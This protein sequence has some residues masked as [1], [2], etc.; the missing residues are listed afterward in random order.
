MIDKPPDK[1]VEISVQHLS[2]VY[3]TKNKGDVLALNDINI[4]FFEGEITGVLGH[5][6]AGKSTLLSI[7]GGKKQGSKIRILKPETCC[8]NLTKS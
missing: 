6:K 7:L 5:E 2:K 3:Y 8:C 4:D 1:T